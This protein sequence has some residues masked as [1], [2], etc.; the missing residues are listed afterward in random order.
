MHCRKTKQLNPQ[1]HVRRELREKELPTLVYA[2][3]ASVRVQLEAG[4]PGLADVRKAL[5]S[6]TVRPRIRER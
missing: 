1:E 5:R 6:L 4:P 2:V 3:L